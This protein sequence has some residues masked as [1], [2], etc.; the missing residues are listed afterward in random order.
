MGAWA[1]R[2]LRVNLSTGAYKFEP[3]DPQLLRDYIGGQGLATRY[4]MDN[5]DPTVD[6]LSP[7]NVLIFAAG[8]LTGTGA[9]AASRTWVVAKSPLT[10]AIGFSTFGGFWG[11]A[12]KRAGLDLVLLEGRAEHP[13]YLVIDDDRVALRDAS[14]LWGMDSHQTDDAI[15]AELEPNPWR[16]EQLRVACIGPA[17]ER[18]VRFASVMADKSRA[19]G[20]TGMGAVMGAK[21]LKAVAVRGT[22]PI[23]VARPREFRELVAEVIQKIRK[24]PVGGQ[25]FPSFGSGG[26]FEFY[27]EVGL[28]PYRNFQTGPFP[29]AAH[30]SGQAIA[31]GFLI[32]N[33][34]CFGC[35]LAC[36]GPCRVD[37]LHFGGVGER[38]EYET[39]A[40]CGASVG[41]DDPR[42][43]LKMNFLCNRLG[44]DTMD[45]GA[46]LACAMEL[47]EKGVIKQEDLGFRY[48]TLKFG[49]ALAA[50]RL[51]QMTGY[52]EGFGD[53][54]AEGGARLAERYGHPEAFMGV[55]RL[56]FP[57]YDVRNAHGMALATATAPRGACHNR[58][59]TIAPEILGV[60]QKVDPVAEQGKAH[61]V[62]ELQDLTAA[63]MDAAGICL[64]SIAGGHVP[65]DM[66]AQLECATGAGYTFEEALRCGERIWNLQRLFNLRAGLTA[67][68]DTVPERFLREPADHGVG[69]GTVVNLKPMLEEYYRLRGWD[70]QGVPTRETLQRLGIKE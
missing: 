5:L 48:L 66:F 11:L 61:L 70:E 38:P 34:A 59:Y 52:R 19:A 64:F 47:Y 6:P 63:L 51:V 43:V 62:R 29:G 65:E 21:R 54:L 10:G 25:A 30:I 1:G 24:H 35:P 15:R 55:K 41:V 50:V 4:L 31:S 26:L 45:M 2:M 3:I 36:G 7:Q 20:R 17:G 37:H 28:V 8:A 9:V 12:L 60:P 18:L 22:R 57:A 44:M 69:A 56:G 53:L 68:D 67:A 42:A 39:L 49:D 40:L 23:E 13:V 32:H 33:K 14:R 58:A 16:A 46:T 27:N